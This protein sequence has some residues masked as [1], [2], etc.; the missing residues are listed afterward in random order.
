MRQVDIYME[1]ADGGDLAEEIE[2]RA[3]GRKHYSEEELMN[4]F[5]DV[6]K[7]VNKAHENGVVHRDIK[8]QNIFL[9]K[10]GQAKLGDFGVAAKC[11]KGSKITTPI[12]TPLY[13][14]PQRVQGRAYGQKADVWSLGCVLYEMAALKPAINARSMP[15]LKRMVANGKVNMNQIPSHYSPQIKSMIS[16][17]LQVQEPAR[18]AM[19]DIIKRTGM[20]EAI[21]RRSNSCPPAVRRANS[22]PAAAAAGPAPPQMS[23]VAAAVNAAAPPLAQTGRAARQRSMSPA[24]RQSF[25]E[26]GRGRAA[27]PRPPTGVRAR[28]RSPVTDAADR[29]RAARGRS[30]MPQHGGINAANRRARSVSPS[31]LA[32]R[33]ASNAQVPSRLGQQ[34][35]GPAAAGTPKAAIVPTGRARQMTPESDDVRQAIMG[36][37]A[38]LNQG[39]ITRRPL[40]AHQEGL[41]GQLNNGVARQN[42]WALPPIPA[43]GKP[44]N[45]WSRR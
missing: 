13:L 22:E 37:K 27:Q 28:S 45:P 30:A 10:E 14:D 25:A 41:V 38:P 40:M 9:N 32:G 19:S 4:R 42:P 35:Q 34:V 16:D 24:P 3:R 5:A 7:A 44:A 6:S 43:A 2:K 18:P 12:G 36:R 29:I 1:Y 21:A 26:R 17:M 8:P 20:K 11:K 15:E 31:Q 23:T 39:G 33:R